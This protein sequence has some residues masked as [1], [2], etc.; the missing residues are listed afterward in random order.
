M[1][2][3]VYLLI[4]FLFC[5][6]FRFEIVLRCVDLLVSFLY[7]DLFKDFVMDDFV[8]IFFFFLVLVGN[9]DGIVVNGLFVGWLV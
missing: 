6:F 5:Y 2:K 9:G 1:S 8:L 3:I 4:I 7:W